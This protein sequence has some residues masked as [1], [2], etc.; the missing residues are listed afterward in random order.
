MTINETLEDFDKANVFEANNAFTLKSCG[1]LKMMLKEYKE[2]WKT[3]T[4]P[5]FLDQ[6]M[7]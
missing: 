5:M 4:R 7:H 6:T 3:L 1:Y 2:A